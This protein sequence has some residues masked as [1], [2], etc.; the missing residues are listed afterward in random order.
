VTAAGGAPGLPLPA[1]FRRR[2]STDRIG[3][4]GGDALATRAARPTCSVPG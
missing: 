4:G 3:L 2:R 1:A